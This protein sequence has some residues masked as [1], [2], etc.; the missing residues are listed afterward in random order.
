M[1]GLKS[2][3]HESCHGGQRSGKTMDKA[4]RAIR[5]MP[6]RA[7]GACVRYGVTSCHD[8]LN[9]VVTEQHGRR[10]PDANDSGAV[11]ATDRS[12]RG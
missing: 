12:L 9:R 2:F 5:K 1:P 7:C 11:E 3:A 4:Q 6:G 8:T 10:K